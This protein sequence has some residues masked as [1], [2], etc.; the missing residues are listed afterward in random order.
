MTDFARQRY[1]Y[2]AFISY[3]SK[4]G[5]FARWLHRSIESYGI[6]TQFISHTTPV[7]EP[8]PRRFSPLFHDRLELPASADLGAEIED[9]LR[10]SRYLI[11]VCSP[12]AARSTWVNKEIE[13][14]KR[15]RDQRHILAI[16]AEGEPHG[17][18]VE[19]CFPPALQAAEPIAADARPH[20]D[21]KNN[22][23][24]KL[25]A[26]MLGVSFDALKQRDAHLKMRRMERALSIAF[27]LMLLFAGLAGVA[28]WQRQVAVQQRKI[29]VERTGT[30]RH[31]LSG[32]IWTLDDKVEGLPGALAVKDDL[33]DGSGAY[34]EELKSKDPADDGLA[35]E[36]A[37]S[38]SK[39]GAVKAE[40]GKLGARLPRRHGRF[41]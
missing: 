10:A 29:A 35:R 17:G 31:V 4:D 24:L 22:A 6:P 30:L 21:G 14:F 12:R 7:G 19:E 36:V 32:L 25:L 34:L 28:W 38:Y 1:R 3:S 2:W 18:E 8:A 39:L 16:I 13:T 40:M 20:A 26:G 11:V 9:A 23:K 41:L 27:L 5:K 33:L 37:V 15:F